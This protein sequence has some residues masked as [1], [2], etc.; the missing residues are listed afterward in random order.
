MKFIKKYANVI[1]FSL[2]ELAV[3]VLLLINPDEFTSRIITMAGAVLAICGL[4][5]VV[6]YFFSSVEEGV[7]RQTM[8]SGLV[9]LLIGGFCLARP[10]WFIITF[11]LMTVV[12]G[13]IVLISGIGNI[14]TT[15]DM[16][17]LKNKKWYL[18]A[19][20]SVIS[21]LAATII[22]KNPFASTADLWMFTGFALIK[23]GLFDIITL[24]VAKKSMNDN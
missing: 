20:N 4:I 21:L 16:I 22:L 14:Q 2:F 10:D 23:E 8:T 15:I 3:G 24:N 17:R 19:L 1:L 7:A 9:L 6:K 11:P 13:V 12:Y 5:N 18:V